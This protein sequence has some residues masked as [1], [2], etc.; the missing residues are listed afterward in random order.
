MKKFAFRAKN[1]SGKLVKGVL[2]VENRGA[3]LEAL[4]SNKLLPLYVGEVGKGFLSD[5][6]NL[7][8]SRVS[9]KQLALFTRQLSTMVTAGLPLTEALALLVN[10]LQGK[11]TIAQIVEHC[12]TTVRAGNTLASAVAKYQKFFGEAYVASIRAGEEGGVLEKILDQLSHNM[13][14]SQDFRAKIKGAMIYP[15]VVITGIIGV[16]FIMMIFVVPKMT[17]LYADFGAKL[18]A[19]TQL[20]IDMSKFVSAIW[21][22]YPFIPLGLFAFYRLSEKNMAV[23]LKR[24]QFLLKIPI[25]G[26]LIGKSVIADTTR[27]LS[28]LLS[29][30]VPMVEAITIIVKVSGNKVFEDAYEKIA[31]RVEK[32]FTLADSFAQT[33]AFPMIVNQMVATGEATGKLDEVLMRVADYFS[34]ESEQSV[35]SLTTAIEPLIMVMLGGVV[36]FLVIAIV[37]PIYSLTSQ[38]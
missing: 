9:Y 23:K 35:K 16:M 14:E 29:A 4:R 15:I 7:F 20:L 37:M 27:T 1:W 30:G 36:G 19:I 21:P 11:G 8:L 38:F 10:Q 25:A 2:E 26:E 13:E 12:L 32:G 33:E 17:S 22:L 5:F 18:P 24:D 3:A 31:S 34:K 6:M 28:M